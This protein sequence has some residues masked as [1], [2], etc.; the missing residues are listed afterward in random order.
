MELAQKWYKD[1]EEFKRKESETPD[2]I[3]NLEY[4]A[5][6]NQLMDCALQLLDSEI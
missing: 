1:A 3:D 4:S 6:A 5:K 2:M